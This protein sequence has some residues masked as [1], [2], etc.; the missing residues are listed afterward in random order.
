MMYLQ[1]GSLAARDRNKFVS[2]LWPSTLQLQ[3]NAEASFYA[4]TLVYG[5]EPGKASVSH[6]ICHL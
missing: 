2:E 3:P 5:W 6:G 4:A 1:H